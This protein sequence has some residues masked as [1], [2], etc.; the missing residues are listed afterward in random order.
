MSSGNN[1]PAS[2]SFHYED[3]MG[4]NVLGASGIFRCYFGSCL[5]VASRLDK[6]INEGHLKLHLGK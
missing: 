6:A 4:R 3:R 2:I 5:T 1:H